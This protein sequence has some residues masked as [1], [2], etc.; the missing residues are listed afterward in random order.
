MRVK[1]KVSGLRA[2]LFQLYESNHPNAEL[3]GRFL[4]T[5]ERR[6]DMYGKPPRAASSGYRVGKTLAASRASSDR[7]DGR[8]HVIPDKGN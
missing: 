7:A 4:N 2:E 8:A 1:R 3:A 5:I 6:R